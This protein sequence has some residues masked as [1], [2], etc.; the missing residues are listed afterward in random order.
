MTEMGK[1][2]P[3]LLER[4]AEVYDFDAHLRGRGAPL[5][6]PELVLQPEQVAPTAPA[7]AVDAPPA[8][9]PRV[10]S[11]VAAID[12]G[13]LADKGLLVPGATIDALVEE[14]RQVKRQ[15]LITARV[16][17]TQD[18]A[19]ARTI[20]VCSANA[21]EGKTYCAVNL[22]I[23]LAAERDN[24]VLLVDADFAKPDVMGRLGLHEGLGL[25]DALAAPVL[26][27]ERFIVDTDIPQL[28]LLPAGTKSNTDTELLSSARTHELIAALL[29]ADPQRIVIFDSPPALAA[30]PASVLAG[31][32]G[33]VM[34]VVRAD[35]TGESDLRE[36]VAELDGC[37][38]IQ[39]VLNS[40]SY[41][42]GGRRYGSYY[43][44]EDAR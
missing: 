25:L 24:N 36:A 5:P 10:G 15:L 18:A 8:A 23:S 27:V 30:S 14:F 13:M 40:V 33:Q 17:R 4:A 37:E 1:V 2:R 12:R 11:P 41:A 7:A 35:R 29:A 26:D 20:L 28:S 32:M 31:L 9:P 6:E 42:P 43:P 34:L 21:G 39:L 19:K 22:A 16:L 38:H 3:S 44:Q